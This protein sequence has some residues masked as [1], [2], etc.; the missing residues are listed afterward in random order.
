MRRFTL[1]AFLVALVVPLSATTVTV[2][3]EAVHGSIAFGHPGDPAVS[4]CSFC[5]PTPVH[6]NAG[7]PANQGNVDFTIISSVWPTTAGL[8]MRVIIEK[9]KDGGAT[10]SFLTGSDPLDPN[11]HFISDTTTKDGTGLI[12]FG[13]VWDGSAMDIRGSFT[14]NQSFS[15]GISASF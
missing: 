7:T 3:P 2:I 10:W 13:T 6:I 11:D 15:W 9:S 14:V 5:G 1:L 4:G 8:T 12:K